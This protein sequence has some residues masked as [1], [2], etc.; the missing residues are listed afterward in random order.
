MRLLIADDH[1]LVRVGLKQLMLERFPG[2]VIGEA[3]NGREA[4][5][6]ALRED[7]DLIILDLA[8]PEKNG[9]EALADIKCAKPRQAVL[10]QSM[11]PEEEIGIRLLKAGAS[12]FI[13]KTAP[14]DDLAGAVRKILGGGRYIS[15]AL[16]EQMASRLTGECEGELHQTLSDREYQVLCM[17]GSGKSATEVARQLSLSIKTISTYRARVFEKLGFSNNGELIRYAIEK[18]LCDQEALETVSS[19]PS[20]P[21]SD[22]KLRA[23]PDGNRPSNRTRRKGMGGR[24][25]R[26]G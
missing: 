12:G 18:K 14:P 2:S 5:A 23:A 9:L 8:M 21:R 24:R 10:I 6:S 19:G 1:T 17:L 26:S 25:S 11:H 15:P 3:K 4:V 13:Q 22:Q 20:R 16:A 7:W